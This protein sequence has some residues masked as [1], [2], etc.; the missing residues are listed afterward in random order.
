MGD[1]NSQDQDHA[2]RRSILRGLERRLS[3]A[4]AKRKHL[5]A[6]CLPLLERSEI[7]IRPDGWGELHG[8]AD[9]RA[10]SITPFS[11]T[12]AFRRLP[13]LWIA[14]TAHCDLRARGV[15]D[16]VRRS[17]NAEFYAPAADL[18]TRFA[19]PAQWP[20]DTLVKGNGA[21]APSTLALL[22][23]PLSLLFAD[24]R[25]KEALVAPRGVRIVYQAREGVRGAYLLFRQSRF[26]VDR[27]H[28]DEVSPLIASAQSLASLLSL[29]P[30]LKRTAHA[31]V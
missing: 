11:E 28:P 24:A 9:G 26:S 20:P 2:W 21:A 30:T 18:P 4:G 31:A 15:L 6:D 23:E 16:V 1:P 29:P 27:L 8:F 12:L 7:R 19:A 3:T 17:T 25:V 14:V 5:L 10:V 13:Q 22:T